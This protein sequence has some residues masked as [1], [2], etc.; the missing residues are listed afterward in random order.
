MSDTA[1]QIESLARRIQEA[2]PS[3]RWALADEALIAVAAT[4]NPEAAGG[5]TTRRFRQALV[6][7]SRLR[8][9]RS[10][11][12]WVSLW[13]LWK[14]WRRQQRESSAPLG[15]KAKGGLF[16][17][18][19][20]LK[21]RELTLAYK[22]RIGGPCAYVDQREPL[23]LRDH[24]R[25]DWKSL[26]LAWQEVAQE[27]FTGLDNRAI[28]FNEPEFLASL[29]RRWPIYA[30]FLASF[31]LLRAA[32]KAASVLPI[33]FATADLSAYAAAAA[34][35]QVIYYQHGFVRRSVV[36][37]DFGEVIALTQPEADHIGNRLP[38]ARVNVA[39]APNS[40]LSPVPRRLAIAGDYL[41]HPID[42]PYNMIRW[43]LENNIEVIVRPHP[44]DKNEMWRTWGEQP[45]VV[46]D[47]RGDFADFL[48]RYRPSALACW[49]ST[50][51]FDALVAGIMP[52]SFES[53]FP[54]LV[55]PYDKIALNWPREQ[56]QIE[57]L[58]IHSEH[59]VTEL[60]RARILA[61]GNQA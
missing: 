57:S 4:G 39:A 49:I 15:A 16:V 30:Y 9:S 3:L 24:V 61:L 45:G 33:G 8:L 2:R 26:L 21:E 60:K 48:T 38:K 34:G 25:P 31:R 19:R 44:A 12:R 28:P 10:I 53:E 52:I 18:I 36:F 23:A 7:A 32:N 56:K 6:F 11:A 50:S 37:P 40:S 27:P 58:L 55:F 13:L 5:V 54:D 59:N 17:G 1:V 51:L 43:S 29:T 41:A 46:V 47:A 42:A 35:Y 22:V 20:A 14:L